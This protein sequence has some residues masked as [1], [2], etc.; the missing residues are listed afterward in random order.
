MTRQLKRAIKYHRQE[1]IYTFHTINCIGI[2]RNIGSQEKQK[3]TKKKIEK[4]KIRNNEYGIHL[5]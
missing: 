5:F 3:Q 2:K 4:E 1:G